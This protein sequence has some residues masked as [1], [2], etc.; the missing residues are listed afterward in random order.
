M[1]WLR[2]GFHGDDQRNRLRTTRNLFRSGL[3]KQQK[4]KRE[5]ARTNQQQ[6]E[7]N[8]IDLREKTRRKEISK[9]KTASR[10]KKR[11]K[12]EQSSN[13]KR[14]QKGTVSKLFVP[15]LLSLC[16]LKF[17]FMKKEFKLIIS[18]SFNEKALSRRKKMEIIKK[19][20]MCDP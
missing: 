20:Y 11:N 15:I 12:Q 19:K 7:G 10:K 1:I 3:F 6:K 2:T 18:I 4:E 13:R 17:W 5:K 14:R 9:E 16:Q 8:G